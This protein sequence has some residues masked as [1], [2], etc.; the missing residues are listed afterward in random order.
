MSKVKT[1]KVWT[2][3]ELSEL[4][5][6]RYPKPE[7]ALL[8]Q[9]RNGTGGF[10]NRS[11][12]AMAMGLWPS[13]GLQIDGF[14]IKVYRNDWIRELRKPDKAEDIAAYC[15]RW[16]IVAPKDL[17]P[18]TELPPTWG[19]LSPAGGRLRIVKQAPELKPIELDKI[20]LAAILRNVTEHMVHERKIAAKLDARFKTGQESGKYE[21]QRAV[22]DLNRLKNYVEAFK[23]ASGVDIENLIWGH[24]AKEVGQAVKMVLE[25]R[26]AHVKKELRRIRYRTAGILKEVDEVLKAEGVDF[27]P[28]KTSE[29]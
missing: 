19:L 15:N 21:A 23:K 8:E 18:V 2:A 9:V 26:H 24:D 29:Y 22:E 6:L 4:L 20:V 25:G 17:I 14:E 16:W 11:A 12:D 27:D 7:Y 5:H 1:E 28:T 13:R 3:D 10:A